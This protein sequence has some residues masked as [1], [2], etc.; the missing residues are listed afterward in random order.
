[1]LTQSPVLDVETLKIGEGNVEGRKYTT[2]SSRAA[3]TFMK[4]SMMVGHEKTDEV[5]D[6][7]GALRFCCWPFAF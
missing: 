7:L 4:R 2:E 1:M 3:T 5:E 6:L